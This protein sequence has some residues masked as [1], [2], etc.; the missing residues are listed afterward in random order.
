MWLEVASR[1][2]GGFAA[3]GKPIPLLTRVGDEA[4]PHD[5][6]PP[7]R[8]SHGGERRFRTQNVA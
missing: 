5:R 2:R 1:P 3:S 7:L 6:N 8:R 4:R